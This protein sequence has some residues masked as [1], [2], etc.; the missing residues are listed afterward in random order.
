MIIIG[1]VLASDDTRDLNASRVI[2]D[3]FFS[4]SERKNWSDLAEDVIIVRIETQVF[5]IF[6]EIIV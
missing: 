3:S 2:F 4:L 6:V 5:E 1:K